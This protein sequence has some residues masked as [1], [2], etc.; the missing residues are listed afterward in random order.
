MGFLEIS[1][2]DKIS[3]KAILERDNT[4]YAYN[5]VG[6]VTYGLIKYYFGA[7]HIKPNMA[8]VQKCI[9]LCSASTK[10]GYTT[11]PFYN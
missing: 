2:F 3:N 6:E 7:G 4:G 1:G 8:A 11:A 5:C 9:L 10:R